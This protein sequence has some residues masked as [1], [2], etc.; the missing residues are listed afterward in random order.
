MKFKHSNYFEWTEYVFAKQE[1]YEKMTHT[2]DNTQLYLPMY[3]LDKWLG[4]KS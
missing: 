3:K 4:K 2:E 1:S